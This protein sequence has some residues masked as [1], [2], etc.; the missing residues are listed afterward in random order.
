MP[1]P[2][3]PVWPA[4]LLR[5]RDLTCVGLETLIDLAARMKAEPAGWVGALPGSTLACLFEQPSVR[6]HASVEAAA[7][8]LGMFPIELDPDEFPL[9]GR[10]PIDQIARLLAAQAGALLVMTT[11]QRTLRT[12]AREAGV[13]ILNALSDENDPCQA[14]GDLL[15]LR[16]RFGG[17]EGLVLAYTGE[18]G[19]VAT[20][21][22]EAGAL[23]AM[24]V[25]IACPPD[26]RPEFEVQAAA[27][28]IAEHH[29]GTITVTDDAEAALADADAVYTDV[30]SSPA[31][32]DERRPYRV[33]PELM[34]RA[35]R[36]AVFMHCLPAHP[37]EEVSRAVIDGPRSIVSEQAANRLPA[38]Q[39]AIYALAGG[40]REV[41]A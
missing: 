34:A 6:A 19:A 20:S 15:T 2:L 38:E 40:D 26:R 35:K 5:V 24:D 18:P 39:A 25:R 32:E 4:D 31:G 27:E 9:D 21:L 37:G 12:L 33:T 3:T 14:V 41:S 23:M 22:M 1:L 36:T 8:R 29:G 28:I 11:S 16:E 10:E 30:W 13:P 17:L 7:H